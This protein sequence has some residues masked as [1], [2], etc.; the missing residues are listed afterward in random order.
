MIVCKLDNVHMKPYRGLSWQ[1]VENDYHQ[2]KLKF[3]S[4]L[5]GFQNRTIIFQLM[6]WLHDQ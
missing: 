2:W 3:C 5:C 1:L 4:V 6:M